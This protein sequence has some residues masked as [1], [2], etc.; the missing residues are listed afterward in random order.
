MWARMW[1]TTSALPG[2]IVG[3]N[4]TVVRRGTMQPRRF[5]AGLLLG[6][7]V[8]GCLSMAAASTPGR[9]TVVSSDNVPLFMNY[10]GYLTDTLNNPITATLPMKFSIYADSFT[11]PALWFQNQNV[12]VERGVFNV[13]LTLQAADTG[14]FIGGLRRWFGLNVSG[15][16]LQ[17][18]TEITSMAYG[19]RSLY[20][21]NSDLLDN[22]HAADLIWNTTNKQATSNFFISGTGKADVQL[23]AS[24]TGQSGIP[25]IVGNVT[26]TNTGVYGNSPSATGVYGN[27]QTATGVNGTS[28]SGTGV[29]GTSTTGTGVYGT[30]PSAAGV[31]GNSQTGTGVFARSQDNA[32][33]GTWGT[34]SASRGTGVAGVG[35]N[36]TTFYVT[37]GTGGAFTARH[38][39][40]FAYGHDT[41]GTGVATMGNR[42]S[43]TVFVLASGS[44]GSF[45]GTTVGV[46]GLARN[47]SGDRSGGFFRTFSSGTDSAYAWVAY[48]QGANKWKILGNGNVST[49][50]ATRDGQR[51]L[52]AP[53]SPEAYFEDFG[54]ARLAAG[55]CRVEL[56]PLFRDCIATGAGHPLRVFVTL[57]DDCNG[58]YVKSDASGF[59][60]YELNGGR[61]AAAFTWRAV[62]SRRGSEDMRL[63][64]APQPPA[65][66]AVGLNPVTAPPAPVR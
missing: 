7:V 19:M 21:D 46:Y 65:N 57:N 18:R 63:P 53:E 39:G 14:L 58:V 42:V 4:R 3:S 29:Y 15:I 32:S 52:F 11:N 61:S 56:D 55:H 9:A 51:V 10:Q 49:I 41:T 8:F 64:P 1:I 16:D 50:M 30:S 25:A 48:N 28:A 13:K 12:V 31:Y 6:M 24:A 27:S 44:G 33:F 26:G 35:C 20:T 40:L 59:D 22:R 2:S 43:D 38:I 62:G 23:S 17:P 34:N 36:D 66:K 45:N 60:V 5:G 47:L 37:C 54:S